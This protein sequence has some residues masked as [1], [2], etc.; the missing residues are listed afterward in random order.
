MTIKF[1]RCL[2]QLVI[3]T[4]VSFHFPIHHAPEE[5]KE[6][7][8]GFPRFSRLDM[9]KIR[10][11]EHTPIG[12]AKDLEQRIRTDRLG[13][14]S[15]W[16]LFT[17][18][19]ACQNEVQKLRHLFSI[20][21]AKLPNPLLLFWEKPHDVV[22]YI[23]EADYL[24]SSKRCNP[25]NVFS[26]IGIKKLTQNDVVVNVVQPVHDKVVHFSGINHPLILWA[27]IVDVI[28]HNESRVQRLKESHVGCHNDSPNQSGGVQF[29][30]SL[31][32]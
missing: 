23:A 11:Q 7:R 32:T 10:A 20:D 12:L 22:A 8:V 1:V 25:P 29:T 18:N 27:V 6:G 5:G 13:L 3:P 26:C 4:T 14:F 21:L 19:D 16:E 15:A 24:M 9:L 17:L 30:L 2:H 28:R 31:V